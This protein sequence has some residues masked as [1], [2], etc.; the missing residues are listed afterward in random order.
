MEVLAAG[1]T[2]YR[3]HRSD[4]G[5]W[6]FNRD[7]ER[8][9]DL[10]GPSGTC[11]L[12]QSDEGAFLEVF[13]RTG[14]VDPIDVS[15]RSVAVMT[16]DRDLR[17]ADLTAPAA[18]G[19]GVTSTVSAGV[20]YEEHS[21]PWARALWTAGFDGLRYALRHDPTGIEIGYAIFGKAGV[22][23]G[24]GPHTTAPITAELLF[25]CLNRWGLHV[26]P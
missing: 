12:A 4:V 18:A 11:Y 23:V 17:L 2:A 15:A 16:L 24:Y 14:I 1:S 10:R 8:R 21:Q 13:G 9:F 3:V 22:S 26:A 5:A 25:R 19:L 6:W 20:P 7:G